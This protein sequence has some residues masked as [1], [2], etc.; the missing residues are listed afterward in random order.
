MSADMFAALRVN[1]LHGRVYTN[2]EDKPGGTPVVVL[3]YALWQRRF[4][5]QMSILDQP[6]IKRKAVCYDGGG[7][8]CP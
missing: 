4:G 2:D 5:G 7:G 6:K 1:A 8:P 3:S